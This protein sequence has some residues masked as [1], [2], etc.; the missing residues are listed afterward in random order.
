MAKDLWYHNI[1]KVTLRLGENL[2]TGVHI[3]KYNRSLV[4]PLSF[5]R[6]LG[7]SLTL[8]SQIVM[9]EKHIFC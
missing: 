2:A 3:P 5:T 9:N 4:S 7:I 1:I 8:D 6:L